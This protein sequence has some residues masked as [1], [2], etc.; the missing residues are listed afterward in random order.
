MDVLESLRMAWQSIG[1]HRLR[2]AL[3]LLGV[4][5][6][7]GAVITFVVL[8][9]SLEEAVVGELTT[10]RSPAMTVFTQPE[11]AD[12][13]G[14]FDG[15]Q[16]VFTERDLEEIRAL[17]GVETVVPQ[18]TV[19]LSGVTYANQTVGLPAL[20]ATTPAYF[21][22][23]GEENFSA[24]GPFEP[25]EAQVVLNQQA[26]TVFRTNVSVG[27][28][29]EIRRDGGETVTATVVGILEAPD[30]TAFG[31]SVSLPQVYGPTDPFVQTTLESPT[32]GERQ[33]V[34]SRLTVV[35][36]DYDRVDDVSDR[37]STYLESDSDAA[38]LLP[39]SYETV[40]RTNEQFV[41]QIQTV[42]NRF[43]GFV[44]A[45][46]LISLVVGAVG[47]ANIMLVSVTERTR[48]IGIMK[49]VGFQNRD[50]LQL[51][52]VEAVVLGLFG[53]ILGLAVGMLAGYGVTQW[54]DL[55]FVLP[56]TW[57]AVAILV[58]IVVGVIAGLYPAWSAARI[59]PI[60]ALRY[61]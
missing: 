50:V 31:P 21:E 26:A 11:G 48:E 33:R 7:V 24:G 25:G 60:E 16:V 35:A 17:Q 47:I 37:V 8:G 28:E 20:T 41:R 27:D 49:A 57:G 58:G 1:S 55:P 13:F 44:T 9:A 29:I 61:E 45:I 2:S 54:L 5:I 19:S 4:V 23:T 56:V 10:G 30:D 52:L 53:A 3:T 18:G 40:V 51:F 34:Y 15:G 39:G 42:L 38:Q 46:A 12:G 22:E 59:D 43:T 6:G 36:V 14:G 32:T